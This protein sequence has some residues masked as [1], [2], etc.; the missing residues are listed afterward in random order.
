MKN[1][2]PKADAGFCP[3][4]EYVRTFIDKESPD[5]NIIQ[6]PPI[7]RNAVWNIAQIERLW[8]SVLRGYPIGSFLVSL[9]EKDVNARDLQNGK[10]LPSQEDGYFLLD[11][12]Q[13]TR[14]LVLGFKPTATARLWV[15]L[16]PTLRFD[17]AEFN[18]R[19][20]MLRVL[21]SYQPWGMNDR[22]PADKLPEHQKYPAREHL[23]QERTEATSLRYDYE[24]GIHTGDVSNDTTGISWPLKAS[25]P[26]PLDALI[27]LCGGTTGQFKAPSWQEVC[28]LVP[29]RH[30]SELPDSPTNHFDSLITGIR[31]ILD[32]TRMVVLLYQNIQHTPVLADEQDDMEVL[33]RR[34]NAGGTVLQGEEMAYSLLKASWDGA[35][36]MVSEIV[37]SYTV[38]YLLS[39]TAIVMA[40]TR[41]VRYSHQENDIANPG[42]S[43]FRKW[44][45]DKALSN[46]FLGG[47]QALLQKEASGMAVM[48]QVMESF[49]QLLLYK[50]QD[51]EDIG[52]PRKLLLSINPVLF[53]PVFIWLHEH[54]DDTKKI[55]E[56]RLSILRYLLYSY[57]T[58]DKSDQTSRI[59]IETIRKHTG[60][61]FPDKAIYEILLDEELTVAI[62]TPDELSKPWTSNQADG[63]FRT[64]H[65]LFEL[66]DDPYNQFRKWFWESSREL[67]LWFQRQ[68]STT[69]FP[70]YNP[71]SSDAFDTPYDWDHIVP[72][73][74]LIG[75]GSN[76]NYHSSSVIIDNDSR[77]KYINSIGNY[78]LWPLWCNR[79][80]G[81]QC[82]TYKLRMKEPDWDDDI[83]KELQL[84][85]VTAFLQASAIDP[86]DE[87]L[88]YNA[89]GLYRDWPEERRIA[90]QTAVEKRVTYLYTTFF[91]TFL[92]KNW[93][94]GIQ[95]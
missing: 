38:G 29:A 45:G 9:R 78:R 53:H 80:D 75:Q 44:I 3:L 55:A 54:K 15:D 24:V 7:Q 5:H 27:A 68:H 66:Q 32:K 19:R 87:E 35:Y 48:Q 77:Y 11:G 13:R 94:P 79:S 51:R 63:T 90:W 4:V 46:S 23:Q 39:P 10:Q 58:V 84:S 42:V 41:I 85:S 1:L 47:M 36:D 25:L 70:G 12:Q 93:K 8:D 92:F 88:W 6:L 28:A 34:I 89:G 31:S 17:N 40:A 43:N 2:F 69:W 49:C 76:N 21:T 33:F 71:T 95:L 74:H 83:V 26:V 82:H 59:A 61:G 60:E 37:N 65:E 18:D 72:Y 52:L 73:S 62:P 64:G 16:N 14:A 56:N 81:N 22:N 30:Q 86:K 20:F 67:L 91:D 50:E 57:L